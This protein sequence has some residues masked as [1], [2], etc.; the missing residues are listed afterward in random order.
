MACHGYGQL[1]ASFSKALE[2]LEGDARVIA[3]PEALNRFYLDD[4]AKRHG[5]DSPVGATWMTREDRLT[6]ISGES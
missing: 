1:G 6:D 2:P 3:V 4:P 5:P